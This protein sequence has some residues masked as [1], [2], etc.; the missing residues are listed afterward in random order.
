MRK[1][2]KGATGA[3]FASPLADGLVEASVNAADH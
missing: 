2:I 3:Y 1:A